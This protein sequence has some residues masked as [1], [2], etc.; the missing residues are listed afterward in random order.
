MNDMTLPDPEGRNADQTAVAGLLAAADRLV[1]AFA[2]HD[3]EAYFA[4]FAP[5]ATFVFHT[6][7]EPLATRAAYEHQWQAWEAEDGFRVHA[8][9]SSDRLARVVGDTGIFAHRVETELEMGGERIVSQERDTIVFRRLADGGWIAIHE[10]LS[11][12]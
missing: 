2:R 6:L 7:A 3:R 11:A 8:C 12:A 1:A 4:A 5:E 10:H 9:C